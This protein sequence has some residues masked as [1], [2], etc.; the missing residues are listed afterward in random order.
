MIIS[1]RVGEGFLQ[2]STDQIR[3]SSLSRSLTYSSFPISFLMMWDRWTARPLALA[4]KSLSNLKTWTSR[5]HAETM[6][7][8]LEGLT[9]CLQFLT[10]DGEVEALWTNHSVC[11]LIVDFLGFNVDFSH[12]RTCIPF[13]RSFGSWDRFVRMYDMIQARFVWCLQI[14]PVILSNMNQIPEP[15]A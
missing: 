4:F 11:I 6:F 9:S 10:Q 1:P 15:W 8:Q 13:C 5:K 7:T 3:S 14:K 12:Y 2:C